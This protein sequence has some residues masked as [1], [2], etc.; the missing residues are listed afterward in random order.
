[1]DSH[2][3][4]KLSKAKNDHLEFL[5]GDSQ[6]EFEL[7]ACF[8]KEFDKQGEQANRNLKIADG[9]DSL[10]GILAKCDKSE[11]CRP[12]VDR[13][14][15]QR[16]K[17]AQSCL[18][19]FKKLLDSKDIAQLRQMIFWDLNFQLSQAIYAQIM[20]SSIFSKLNSEFSG[21]M[22]GGYSF[23]DS[24]WLC[25]YKLMDEYLGLNIHSID[26]NFNFLANGGFACF[27]YGKT[28]IILKRPVIIQRNQNLVLHCED[29]P[30]VKWADGTSLYFWNGVEV[31]EKLI[32]YPKSI[33]RDDILAQKNVEVRRCYQEVLGSELFANLLG[34]IP[35]DRKTDR[36]GNG[37]VLYRTLDKDKLI[38]EHI[39]FAQV[40][41]PST[42]R[43]YFL[44]VP[45][46]ISS[47][48]EAVAW[49][50]GKSVKDYKPER[51]T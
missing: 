42:G 15:E 28:N 16:I 6:D 40:I 7:A 36:F 4:N 13:L 29:G 14:A 41:C 21:L 44:C 2:L 12:I 49:T 17:E 26:L 35:I 33:T 9:P 10:R 43:N 25:F 11:G 22:T 38:G 37:M 47:V 34:L 50:F 1:M 48:D 24:D 51:E 5:L 39:H 3:L 46:K 45:P 19:S 20:E 18:Q 31:S 30:A 32:N 23:E 8:Q 27:F